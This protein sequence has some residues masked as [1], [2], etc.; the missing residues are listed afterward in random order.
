MKAKELIN[1]LQKLDPELDV[2]YGND[3]WAEI[4]TVNVEKDGTQPPVIVLD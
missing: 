2:V 1:E 3:A 4:T